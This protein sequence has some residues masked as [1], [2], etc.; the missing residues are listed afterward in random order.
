MIVM[1]CEIK[2]YLLLDDFCCAYGLV[3][4]YIYFRVLFFFIAF[5]QSSVS[6]ICCVAEHIP[7]AVMRWRK[8]KENKATMLMMMMRIIFFTFKTF[9]LP[10]HINIF[11]SMKLAAETFMNEVLL[12]LWWMTRTLIEL[13]GQWAIRVMQN[14]AANGAYIFVEL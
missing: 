10:E 5:V 7:R 12:W 13:N 3:P 11:D 4:L 9:R 6:F 1:S 8:C 2:S 14:G